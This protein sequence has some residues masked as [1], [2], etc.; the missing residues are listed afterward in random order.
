MP[1]LISLTP[2]ERMVL[3]QRLTKL[4]P[5][6]RK[7]YPLVKHIPMDTIG[8]GP[9]TEAL[10]LILRVG[11]LL[12]FQMDLA[13]VDLFYLNARQL[14][15]I[16]PQFT[17]AC[18]QV[19]VLLNQNPP[20]GADGNASQSSNVLKPPPAIQTITV[21]SVG[22]GPVTPL[23]MSPMFKDREL[24]SED[25]E[26]ANRLRALLRQ[27][28]SVVTH[29]GA[30]RTP[31][32]WMQR[33]KQVLRSSG[34]ENKEVD[35]R[36]EE[37]WTKND[38]HLVYPDILALPSRPMHRD[39]TSSSES[40]LELFE[41]EQNVLARYTNAEIQ[42][43]F[44]FDNRLGCWMDDAHVRFKVVQPP[45]DHARHTEIVNM[46][47]G[48]M[49]QL[50]LGEF[51]QTTTALRFQKPQHL[52]APLIDSIHPAIIMDRYG[53][54]WALQTRLDALFT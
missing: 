7:F 28:H 11:M 54:V 27:E 34:T 9:I 26:K 18:E 14:D 46:V 21:S 16:E 45:T 40:G 50:Q 30:I 22:Q 31:E 53:P 15:R 39:A 41:V 49:K 12:Q 8:S 13:K 1:I 23:L 4:D 51:A 43:D 3:R 35:K 36:T 24:S 29:S 17:A 44:L 38:C 32:E 19:D 5:I 42:V 10:N 6:V 20:A 52:T 25:Q 47:R 37:T 2:N 48:V 33:F